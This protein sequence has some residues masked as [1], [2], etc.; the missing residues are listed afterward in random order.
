MPEGSADRASRC[1]RGA[2]LA[3]SG[4][5]AGMEPNGQIIR[6]TNAPKGVILDVWNGLQL[7]VPH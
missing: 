2:Q 1:V 6:D 4:E 7:D 3:G 5:W